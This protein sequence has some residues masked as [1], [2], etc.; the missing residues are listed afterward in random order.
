[1]CDSYDVTEIDNYFILSTL[2]D[3]HVQEYYIFVYRF[4][5]KHTEINKGKPYKT[6]I[7]L[8]TKYLILNWKI[9]KSLNFISFFKLEF[10]I[11]LL[12]LD[13]CFVLILIPNYII[14][15]YSAHL[16]NW[17]GLNFRYYTCICVL[18]NIDLI[19]GLVLIFLCV[20]LSVSGD[21]NYS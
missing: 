19:C 17:L 16:D 14:L 2:Q 20:L 9:V 15:R 11:F 13:G 6:T 7:I 3:F 18:S 5:L 8:F 12:V 1:M 4:G 21:T 10:S